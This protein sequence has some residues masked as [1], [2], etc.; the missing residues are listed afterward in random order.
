MLARPLFAQLLSEWAREFEVVVL[1]SAPAA[2]Y[3]DARTIAAHSGA[4]LLVARKNATRVWQ[5]R[6][7]SEA[8]T[9]ARTIILGA[10]LNDF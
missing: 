5:M 9:D 3:T 4:A 2:E 10:V 7:V 1:D 6:S 8:L